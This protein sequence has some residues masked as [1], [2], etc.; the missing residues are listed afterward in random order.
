MVAEVEV[1]VEEAAAV[2]LAAADLAALLAE[3]E[4]SSLARKSRRT[5]RLVLPARSGTRSI[6]SVS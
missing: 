1:E 4:R 5:S 6:T 2:D 3:V